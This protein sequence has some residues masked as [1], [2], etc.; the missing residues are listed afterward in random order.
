MLSACLFE[1]PVQ[2]VNKPTELNYNHWL[3]QHL[4]IHA[5]TEVESVQNY[6]TIADLYTPLSDPFTRYVEPQ[7]A[8]QQ[9][10]NDTSTTVP[11]SIG[12]EFLYRIDSDSLRL[13]IYRVY[14]YSPAKNAGLQRGDRIFSINGI[15]LNTDSAYAQFQRIRNTNIHLQFVI[16]RAQ[17][18][19][20]IDTLSIELD[21]GLVYVP[22]VFVDT[23]AGVEVIQIREFN[24][25]SLPTG[26]TQVEFRQALS[27]TD[28][29]KTRILDLRGNPGG[30]VGVCL[31]VAD[32]LVSANKALIHLIVR[33]FDG[34]G[35]ITID[36]VT[37]KSHSMGLGETAPFYIL[38]DSNS[39]SCA[40]IFIAAVQ[41]NRE[42]DVVFMGTRSYGKGIG[43]SRWNTPLGG[44]ASITNLEIRTPQWTN[45]HG[46][47]LPVDI[48]VDSGN[49][50]DQALT[51]LAP[52]LAKRHSSSTAQSPVILIDY[53]LRSFRTGAWVPGEF[54]P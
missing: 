26:G 23:L 5:E 28:S 32:E 47:G 33:G 37:Y 3:L 25:N 48:T 44:L 21:K 51:L 19:G 52:P 31:E 54:V 50:L 49:I 17:E 4:Y 39:A 7:D 2:V 43:Q 8:D 10:H 12:I 40:E 27:Q 24:R 13:E 9:R 46:A 41:D 1:M 36:S 6:T 22:T 20:I 42:S 29:S 35:T 16:H 34:R 18:T 45:Y 14:P 30:E 38:M 15:V 11:G 53:P